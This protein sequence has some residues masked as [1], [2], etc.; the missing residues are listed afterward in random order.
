MEESLSNTDPPPCAAPEGTDRQPSPPDFNAHTQYAF[1]C[2]AAGELLPASNAFKAALRL[3]PNDIQALYNVASAEQLLGHEDAAQQF[4]ALA[5]QCVPEGDSGTEAQDAKSRKRH[6]PARQAAAVTAAEAERLQEQQRPSEAEWRRRFRCPRW[7]RYPRHATTS[8]TPADCSVLLRVQ[9]LGREG[10][11]VPQSPCVPRPPSTPGRVTRGL[12]S[13]GPR[14]R[15]VQQ[16]QG[17]H[18]GSE[19]LCGLPAPSPLSSPALRRVRG[20]APLVSTMQHTHPSAPLPPVLPLS[21]SNPSSDLPHSNGHPLSFLRSTA[22]PRRGLSLAPLA[23][24]TATVPPVTLGL[25]PVHNGLSLTARQCIQLT[26][27]CP[28]VM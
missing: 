16:A 14:D 5:M 22:R 1:R 18:V 2:L 3:R 25:S 23:L 4:L 10:V 9:P 6:P 20:R 7:L 15:T 26:P 28:S 11:A 12:A 8:P 13:A 27:L 19:L 17:E 24:P 21:L